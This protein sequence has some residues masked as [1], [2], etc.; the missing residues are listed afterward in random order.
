MTMD[1]KYV[2]QSIEAFE[3]RHRISLP[4]EYRKFI[5]Q[6]GNGGAGPY[7]GLFPFGQHDDG[8]ALGSWEKG[9][10]L[11]D[12]SRPFA[13]QDS[14]NL[15][16]SF[17][18]EEPHST[19][20]TPSEEEDELWEAWDR[21]LEAHYWNGSI[22]DGAIPICHLGCALRHW[23]VVNGPC[24]GEI[25]EDRRTENNGLSPVLSKDGKRL[26]FEMWYMFWLEETLEEYA[27]R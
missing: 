23:L 18:N 12:V 8:F 17:W 14:W 27:S 20:D 19:E 22:M 1:P 6:I 25:W 7:Y 4:Q 2:A 16:E 11:G 3:Q 13:Y 26:T 10:L 9:H 21:R 5:C 24:R 15:P